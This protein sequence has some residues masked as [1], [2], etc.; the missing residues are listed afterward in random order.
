MDGVVPQCAPQDRARRDH[1]RE[2][3]D[4]RTDPLSS[5]APGSSAE[6]PVEGRFRRIE[7]IDAAL[8]V[9]LLEVHVGS[10]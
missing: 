2:S 3:H 9:T 7:P 5:F 4:G 1:D 8:K 6:Q 10:S